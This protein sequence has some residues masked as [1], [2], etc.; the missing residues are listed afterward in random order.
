MNG[1]DI[2]VHENDTDFG[3]DMDVSDDVGDIDER[4]SSYDN[5]IMEQPDI[6]MEEPDV[7][8]EEP[9]VYVGMEEPIL[10]V[11]PTNQSELPIYPNAR[12]SLATSLILIMTFALTHHLS[13]AALS[14]L[15]ALVNLHCTVDVPVLQSLY[16]FKHHFNYKDLPLKYHYYCPKCSTMVDSDESTECP[17]S[18]CGH[19]FKESK[20]SFF[21][22][23]PIEQ[24]L[25]NM[26]KRQGFYSDLQYRFNRDKFSKSAI[27][28]IYDGLLYKE[29]MGD[30]GFLTSPENISF[31]LNTDGIA[32]FKSSNV[33]LWPIYLQIN[34]LPYQKRKL[35][36]NVIL[37]GLWLGEDKP[38]MLNFFEPVAA[39]L[40][41]MYDHG[42]GV[43]SPDVDEMI[44]C[45]AQLLSSSF[46]LP[47]KASVLNM[48]QFNG[49]YG[50][51]NCIQSGERIKTDRGGTTR[52]YP[53]QC[54]NPDGPLRS[55]ASLVKDAKQ[56][57]AQG[58]PFNGVK[59]PSYI[60]SV[61]VYDGI[62]GTVV[63]YMHC[64]LL[65]VTRLLLCLWFNTEN[66][67]ELWYCGNKVGICDKRLL[68]IKPPMY[69]SRTP[70][71]IS[72]D[73]KH[74][75]ASEYRN[76]LLYYSIPVMLN[77]LPPEY[78]SHHMLLVQAI[79]VLL[80]DSISRKDLQHARTML[81]HFCFKFGTF[82]SARSMTANIHSLLHLPS[83]V[84]NIGPL[85]MSSCFGFETLNGQLLNLSNGTQG[86]SHQI[87]Q[88]ISIIQ[89]MP[90]QISQ[91]ITPGSEG[92]NLYRHLAKKATTKLNEQLVASGIYTVGCAQKKQ[93]DD[94]HITGLHSSIGCECTNY[95]MY[96]RIRIE[97]CEIHSL[98]Y[99]VP[100]K[101]NTYTICFRYADK[102]QHG[103]VLYFIHVQHTWTCTSKTSLV[104]A[105]RLFT[106]P[107]KLLPVDTVTNCTTPHITVYNK[108][109]TDVVFITITSIKCICVNILFEPEFVFIA[110]RPNIKETD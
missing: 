42:I 22:T 92:D 80:G 82:Y 66:H 100:K 102:I 20:P 40:K 31:M 76:W 43:S 71:T 19:D 88:A 36:E 48:T 107:V 51:S 90:V 54:N 44:T 86:I 98:L 17:N 57:F 34:E 62:K 74:W 94:R 28:D 49:E 16:K 13:G 85:F 27:E 50:C 46:D 12:I 59:G 73:R 78:L 10:S 77:I 21:I 8:M 32:V 7:G 101:R 87:A 109:Y 6:G 105:V 2:D 110:S 14:D 58:K 30:G 47:A 91:H 9:D 108:M 18:A 60:T 55:H 103:E 70:R 15:L 89:I 65:G 81:N 72:R 106:R 99:Q 26:F 33:S 61:P 75:K 104:A 84:E 69:V 67:N 96:S 63:D 23:I 53:Y 1:D 41:N 38:S 95:S 52:V 64:V 5:T 11:T 97:S 39:N 79:H 56:A 29:H 3:K 4:H 83:V 68:Q 37:C 25:Q 24:Q 35:K 45:K 93:L